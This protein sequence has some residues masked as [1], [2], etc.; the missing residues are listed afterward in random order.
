MTTLVVHQYTNALDHELI[1]THVF[2]DGDAL[3][4]WLESQEVTVF[5]E[6]EPIEEVI[7]VRWLHVDRCRVCGERVADF[8][9]GG[10][11]NED[12]QR[13]HFACDN[14]PDPSGD[15]TCSHPEVEH[16]GFPCNHP[17]FDPYA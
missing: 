5:L 1:E 12:G 4:A 15:T 7:D 6:F 10:Y 8:E 3:Q 14:R 9:P 16:P 2:P 13:G 11:E 17:P